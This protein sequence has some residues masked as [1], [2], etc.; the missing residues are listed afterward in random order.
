MDKQKALQQVKENVKNKN[1]IKHMLAAEIVM[2]GLAV[3]FEEDADKW[4]LAGLL[5]DIDY[6]KTADDPFTHSKLGAEMLENYGY[7]EDIVYAVK[8]HNCAH[9]LERKS[10]MDKAL[11]CADPLT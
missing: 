6:D 7:S 5:H 9:G 1:L 11:Y 10:M 4:G 2:R 3:N 8:V